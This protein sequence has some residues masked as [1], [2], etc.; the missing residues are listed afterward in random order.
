MTPGISC[1]TFEFGICTYLECKF[2]RLRDKL[3]NCSAVDCI[4]DR[5]AAKSKNLGGHVERRRAAAAGGAI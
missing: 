4:L 2:N 1:V 5:D 3:N